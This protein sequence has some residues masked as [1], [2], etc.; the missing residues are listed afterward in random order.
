[1]EHVSDAEVAKI[2]ANLKASPA[3]NLELSDKA[4]AEAYQTL[5]S[6]HSTAKNRKLNNQ[7]KHQDFLDDDIEQ[8][9][10]LIESEQAD[11]YSHSEYKVT[12]FVKE[13]S[14]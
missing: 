1:M 14:K 10:R 5:S 4:P 6:N 8:I 3:N 12:N 13:E 11:P 9:D 7:A 2:F